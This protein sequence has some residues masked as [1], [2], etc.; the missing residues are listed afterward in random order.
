MYLYT[1]FQHL[2]VHAL[3]NFQLIIEPAVN[4]EEAYSHINNELTTGLLE[5]A[6]SVKKW[7]TCSLSAAKQ[8]SNDNIRADTIS[9]TNTTE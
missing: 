5:N 1:Y 7:S 3:S 8:E 4:K 6:D 2:H 9:A